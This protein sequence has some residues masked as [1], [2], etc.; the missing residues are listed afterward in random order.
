[1]N[2]S[3]LIHVEYWTYYRAAGELEHSSFNDILL[4]SHNAAS[5]HNS[6]TRWQ[7][8]GNINCQFRLAVAS[9][10]SYLMKQ[11]VIVCNSHSVQHNQN[12]KQTAAVMSC[13]LMFCHNNLTLDGDNRGQLISSQQVSIDMMGSQEK[14]TKPPPIMLVNS[15]DEVG[16]M[17][18]TY[19]T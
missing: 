12:N 8:S 9:K 4:S 3:D 18:E 7:L 2:V 19:M 16:V 11:K 15:D 14:M 5:F 1:M 10:R 6:D 13:R 17:K